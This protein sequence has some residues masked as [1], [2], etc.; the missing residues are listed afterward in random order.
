MLAMRR[1]NN[2]AFATVLAAAFLLHPALAQTNLENYHP[3]SFLVPILG[4]ALY[5]AVENKPRMFVV[6][7]VLALLCKEDVALILLPI[8]I[9]YALRHNRRLGALIAGASIL[10]ALFATNVIMR[11]LIGVPTLNSGRIPF[12]GGAASSKRRSRSPPTS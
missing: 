6:L 5:A 8:A 3:D 10:Y 1:L 11:S 7:S 12:G 9:W 4:F 2:P